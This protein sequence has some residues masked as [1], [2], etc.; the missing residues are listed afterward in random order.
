MKKALTLLASVLVAFGL[1]S[2]AAVPAKKETTPQPVVVT[3]LASL[4]ADSWAG[5]RQQKQK[6]VSPSHKAQATDKA[7]PAHLKAAPAYLKAPAQ[8]KAAPT[9]KAPAPRKKS[10]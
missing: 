2:R 10:H 3:G 6:P 9:Q 4:S 5:G 8:F 1:K 7:A